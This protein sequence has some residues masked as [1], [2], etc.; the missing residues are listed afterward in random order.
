[1]K[2]KLKKF[3]LEDLARAAMHDGAILAWEPGLGKSLAAF[4]WPLAKRASRVLL[5]APGGL[6]RQLAETGLEMF[7]IPVTSLRHS[8]HA[9]G[10]RLDRPPLQGAKPRFFVTTYQD[11][12]F[13]GGDEWLDGETVEGI[14]EPTEQRFRRRCADL[15]DLVIAAQWAAKLTGTDFDMKAQAAPFF[16]GIGE[17]RHGISCIWRPT[18]ARTLA[19]FT[20][21]GGGFDCVVVDEGTK[22]QNTESHMS[23][24]VRT[25]APRYRLVLTGTPIKNR[26]ESIFWLAW[27]ACG[28]SAR[29]TARWPYAGT[30]EA[31]EAF[32]NQHL[33]HDRFVDRE[34]EAERKA[35]LRG[36]RKKSRIQRRSARICNIHRLWKLLSP[37]VIRRR[38]EECGEDIPGK[39]VHPISIAPGSAQLA[40]YRYHLENPPAS[41]KDG[42]KLKDARAVK[43]MQIN[44]LR[45]AALCPD[46]ESLAASTSTVMGPKRSWTPWTPKLAAILSLVAD[47]LDEGEPVIIGSPFRAFSHTLADRLREA[48]VTAV[49]L[50]GETPANQRGDLAARFK[51]HEFSVMVAGIAA[52]AEGHSFEHCG[53]LILPSL[54]WAFD[55]NEQFTHRVWRINSPKEVKIYPITMAGSVDMRLA[56]LFMEKGDS[57]ALALD[58]RLFTD[59]QEEVNLDALLADAVRAFKKDAAT[60]DEQSIEAKWE[61]SLKPRLRGS[62]ERFREWHPPIVAATDGTVTSPSEMQSAVDAIE[63]IP[64]PTQLAVEIHRARARRKAA[65]AMDLDAAKRLARRW[66]K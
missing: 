12:G 41:N 47:C 51:A 54:S 29:P 11:L 16:A 36:E 39:V 17:T 42:K 50:D 9:R 48:G 59:K 22:L 6:H 18:L 53:R 26:L 49:L 37:V 60:I 33:Q 44:L 64:S 55:E 65:P 30:S 62:E 52:M 24:G 2:L 46:A 15:R 28:G 19:E 14:R 4:A 27:W 5:V 61:K 8:D 23:Q 43:G 21:T 63:N 40:V 13:N 66:H 58:G 32:A 38:K 7:G 45:Q 57:A 25:L 3:Q 10:F 20:R 34:K 35:A 56:E 31:K 1:M